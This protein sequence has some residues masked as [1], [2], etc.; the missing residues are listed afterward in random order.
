MTVF[1]SCSLSNSRAGNVV[2]KT[3][4]FASINCVIRVEVRFVS[5][6]RCQNQWL[7]SKRDSESLNSLNAE[8]NPTFNLLALLG[9]HHIF[10]VSGLRVNWYTCTPWTKWVERRL[11]SVVGTQLFQAVTL[12]V[13]VIVYWRFGRTYR[14]H[15]QGSICGSQIR[16]IPRPL[17]D[18]LA[19]NI[20]THKSTS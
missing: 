4:I 19:P 10:H 7:N 5:T 17:D 3:E 13:V 2:Y 15:L 18:E 8:L 14:S 1:W 20:Q 6:K 11:C 12:R 9:A 16:T